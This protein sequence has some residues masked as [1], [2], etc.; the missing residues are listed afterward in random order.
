MFKDLPHPSIKTHLL[1]S[2]TKLPMKLSAITAIPLTFLF[3]SVLHRPSHCQQEYIG[4]P[5]VNCSS[6]SLDLNGFLCSIPQSRCSTFM[7]FRSI[8]P[9]N[10]PSSIANL[11]D[12]D[13]SSV[14]SLNNTFRLLGYCSS[15][16]FLLWEQISA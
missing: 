14:A 7:T 11:L 9:Y 6:A 10:T 1:V 13:P 4:G 8:P 2:D 5:V 12:S 3:M 16:L 15:F